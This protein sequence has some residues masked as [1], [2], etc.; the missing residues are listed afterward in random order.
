MSP[1]TEAMLMMRPLRAF[2]MPRRTAFDSRYTE[3][4]LVWMTASQSSCF[5]RSRSMS[6]VMPALLHRMPIAPSCASMSAI[7]RVDGRLARDV[8][9]RAAATARGERLADAR[10]ALGGGGGADDARA[11]RA[12][13]RSAMAAPIPREAPVTKATSP[14]SLEVSCM[15]VLL[16]LP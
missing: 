6:R 11:L 10:G 2:I 4:R 3:A 5:M 13:S 15:T 16:R 7:K 8:E 1:T 9:H 12:E 14:F